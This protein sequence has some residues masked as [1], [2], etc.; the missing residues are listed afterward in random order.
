MLPLSQPYK[1][2]AFTICATPAYLFVYGP[3]SLD[4]QF[5]S[6]LIS[7]HIPIDN[8]DCNIFLFVKVIDLYRSNL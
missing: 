3:H 1:D 2:Y 7:N 5:F 4:F 8:C 6:F